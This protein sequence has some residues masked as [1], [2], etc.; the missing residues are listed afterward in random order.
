[1]ECIFHFSSRERFFS[2]ARRV[3]RPG[4]RL[5]ISDFVPRPYVVPSLTF[6]KR[7]LSWH[8]ES[9]TG[10]ID[11]RCTI[12]RYRELARSAG[13]AVVREDDITRNTL[14][15]YPVLRKLSPETGVSP[16]LAHSWIAA[17][18]LASRLRALRYMI[19]A[20]DAPAATDDGT[21]HKQQA[22]ARRAGGRTS[23]S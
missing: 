8:I 12:E 23:S 20:F 7:F 2:E 21:R 9:A 18:Q 6:A 11:I 1:V 4:G 16:A 15:T 3:L 17:I 22:A 5:C 13:L 10:P 14:P 19:L